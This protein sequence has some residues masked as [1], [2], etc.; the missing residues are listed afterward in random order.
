[1][2]V[3]EGWRKTVLD[4]RKSVGGGIVGAY[5]GF[6]PIGVRKEVRDKLGLSPQAM[7][8]E[9]FMGPNP[10]GAAY[11]AGVRQSQTVTAVNGESPN[12]ADRSFLVWFVQHFEPGDEVTLTVM[13][14]KDH[15]REIAFKLPPRGL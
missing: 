6:F 1:L 8:I 12:V 4:W 5:P 14:D 7:A 2:A 15:R 11:D 10:K 13:E 3:K 9:P